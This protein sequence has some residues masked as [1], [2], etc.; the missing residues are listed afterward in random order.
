MAYFDSV[1]MD[2]GMGT[3]R[4]TPKTQENQYPAADTISA[5][6]AASWRAKIFG[7]T[8]ERQLEFGPADIGPH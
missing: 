5:E 6:P 2:T 1:N 8:G 4:S 7:A 3:L